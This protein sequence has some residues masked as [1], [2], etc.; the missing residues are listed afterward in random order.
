M[1]DINVVEKLTQLVDAYLQQPEYEHIFLV[2]IV[3][4][5]ANEVN[6]YIDSDAGLYLEEAAKMS[7]YLEQF[8][9]EYQWLG[10]KYT[11]EVSS[12]G[13]G[14]PLKIKRQY[15]K[16]IGRELS[17]ELLDTHI[18]AKGT[19]TAVNEDSIVVSYTTKEQVEGTKK[20]KTVEVNQEIPFTNIKKAVVKISFK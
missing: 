9:D 17:V 10:E 14:N 7:R 16:N 8:L 6:V 11:L 19:L 5:R 13:V 20:K 4:S 18:N 15:V 12:P 1:A 2:E 3:L